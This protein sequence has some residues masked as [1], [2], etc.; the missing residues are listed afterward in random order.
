MNR[1]VPEF[2]HAGIP[3]ASARGAPFCSGQP[4]GWFRLE[5]G[6]SPP[7][8]FTRR[9]V[10]YCPTC[11]NQP[12]PQKREQSPTSSRFV[13]AMFLSGGWRCLRVVVRHHPKHFSIRRQLHELCRSC[14]LLICVV[15]HNAM[16]APK[17][18]LQVK[19]QVRVGF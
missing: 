12:T 16:Q 2:S 19:L 15:Q 6:G 17:H 3:N 4:S 9:R 13:A 11:K 14:P 1:S 8:F 10:T 5:C 18:I 7:L